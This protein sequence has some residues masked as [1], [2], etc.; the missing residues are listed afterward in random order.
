M[1]APFR[2]AEVDL[3]H[4]SG[5]SREFDLLDQGVAH[6][7]VDKSGSWFSYQGERIGQGRD[8]ACSFL[9]EHGDLAS[10]L[11]A[12]LRQA[13]ELPAPASLPGRDAERL[14]LTVKVA[15]LQAQ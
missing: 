7:L 10:K 3:I 14:H 8:N 6:N 4:G 1:A 11:D 2:E 13:L 5:V 9:K 12:A 15:A